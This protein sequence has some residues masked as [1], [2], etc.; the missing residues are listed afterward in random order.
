[1]ICLAI[2][3]KAVSNTTSKKVRIFRPHNC[4]GQCYEVST[5]ESHHERITD[6]RAEKIWNFWYKFLKNSCLHGDRC[7]R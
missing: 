4:K 6:K 2:E 5:L 3:E 7:T 1:M